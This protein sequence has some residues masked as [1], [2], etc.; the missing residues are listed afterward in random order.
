[1]R[2]LNERIIVIALIMLAAV[3]VIFLCG[4]AGDR[5][6][7]EK[8]KKA[9]DELAAYHQ[10]LETSSL[11]DHKHALNNIGC[12]D[13]HGEPIPKEGLIKEK[14]LECHGSYEEVAEKAP[15][16][17]MAIQPHFG[18]QETECNSCHKAHKKS[19]LVC[20]QCHSFD[21]NVP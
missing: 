1:M 9:E 12:I 7:H 11:L 13:C 6:L 21:M 4:C 17:N 5:A 18:E 10:S 14:C 3:N 8:T 16:H 19:G 2:K 15:T 20:N